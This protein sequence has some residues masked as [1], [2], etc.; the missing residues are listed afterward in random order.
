MR[1]LSRS[2][3]A[4]RTIIGGGSQSESSQN[5]Q[6]LVHCVIDAALRAGAEQRHRVPLSGADRGC[7]GASGSTTSLD[8]PVSFTRR[9]TAGNPF[10]RT[11]SQLRAVQLSRSNASVAPWTRVSRVNQVDVRSTRLSSNTRGSGGDPDHQ[12]AR[13]HGVHS[14]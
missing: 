8:P 5:A 3:S 11:Y 12:P 4:R 13:I 1:R 7:F 6:P 14:N 9:S 2:K 10:I